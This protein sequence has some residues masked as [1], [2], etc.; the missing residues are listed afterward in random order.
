MVFCKDWLHCC[1]MLK[2]IVLIRVRFLKPSVKT[3]IVIPCDKKPIIQ[4]LDG[5]EMENRGQ[6]SLYKKHMLQEYVKHP[7]NWLCHS[8]VCQD[9]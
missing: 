7:K 8:T 1:V 6:I 4:K 5:T 2:V 9:L 3:S